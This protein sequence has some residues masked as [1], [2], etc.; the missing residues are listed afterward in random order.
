MIHLGMG[1]SGFE[2]SILLNSVGLSYAIFG[3]F[4]AIISILFC[5]TLSLQLLEQCD[6]ILDL[7]L[8]SYRSLRG[9][10][11]VSKLFSL[12]CPNWVISIDLS[13]LFSPS[14]EILLWL[15]SSQF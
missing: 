3:S 9:C 1:S 14:T 2:G 6:D 8:K 10:V 11:C 5:P 13:S 4:S 12:C 7:L 15:F